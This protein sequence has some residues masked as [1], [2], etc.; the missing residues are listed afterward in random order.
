VRAL[1]CGRRNLRHDRHGG[2]SSREGPSAHLAP[3]RVPG[4]TI[5]TKIHTPSAPRPPRTHMSAEGAQAE[6]PAAWALGGLVGP[7]DGRQEHAAAC[8]SQCPPLSRAVVNFWVLLEA[9]CRP[10]VYA[11]LPQWDCGHAMP[12]VWTCLKDGD[13]SLCSACRHLRGRTD[14]GSATVARERQRES[15]KPLPF[16]PMD[17]LA[18][19]RKR[20]GDTNKAATRASTVRA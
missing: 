13:S 17:V 6:G 7:S 20:C 12:L 10:A 3:P 14:T 9:G 18:R 15:L 2:S 5:A 16:S 11:C 4:D 19:G 8:R 1:R